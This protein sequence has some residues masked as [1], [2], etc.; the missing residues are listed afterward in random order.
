MKKPPFKVGD[1]VLC[2]EGNGH[3]VFTGDVYSVVNIHWDEACR[4]WFCQV[5]ESYRFHSA[6]R[7][8]P[9]ITLTE[10]DVLGG[11]L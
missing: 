8:Q 7:F 2:V 11:V 5:A 1:I 4:C 6:S 3:N 9:V 10:A